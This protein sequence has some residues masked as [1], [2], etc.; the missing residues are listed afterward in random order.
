VEDGCGPTN[1][2][3]AK[4][5]ELCCERRIRH[6]LLANAWEWAVGGVSVRAYAYMDEMV[7]VC[8]CG[9]VCVCVCVRVCV[10]EYTSKCVCVCVCVCVC[11][12]VCA[13]ARV[14]HTLAAQ[15]ALSGDAPHHATS[16]INAYD[17]H[18]Q[19]Q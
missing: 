4:P 16:A 15:P 3:L 14:P 10:C 13:R 7:C 2:V 18:S 8:V 6:A 1:K 12:C 17:Q 11:A 19:W 5:R 9:C